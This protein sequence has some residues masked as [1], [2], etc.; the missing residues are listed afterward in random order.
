MLLLPITVLPTPSPTAP[1]PITIE[2]VSEFAAKEVLYPKA[3]LLEPVVSAS[4]A[5][6]PNKVF[7]TLVEISL[8]DSWPIATL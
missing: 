6:P 8:P 7:C 3:T 5:K 1:D 4:P 2:L